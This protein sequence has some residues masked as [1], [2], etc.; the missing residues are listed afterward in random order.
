METEEELSDSQLAMLNTA[1]DK[2]E[3]K[4]LVLLELDGKISE[5]IQEPD[6]LE[7]EV[8]EAEDTH[9]SIY[10][11]DSLSFLLLQQCP[12]FLINRTSDS[13]LCERD[14]SLEPQ[15]DCTTISATN[16][17]A[18]GNTWKHSGFPPLLQSH[19][20]SRIT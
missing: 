10:E 14:R 18:S 8:L 4:R 17:G 2:F 15:H 1:L 19:G 12:A 5:A 11:M 9:D 3:W 20:A 13:R 7:S 6:E 16:S